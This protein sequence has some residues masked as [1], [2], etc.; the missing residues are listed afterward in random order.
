[1]A[2]VIGMSSSTSGHFPEKVPRDN[3]V[4]IGAADAPRGFFCDPAWTHITYAAAKTGFAEC[5][6][7]ALCIHAGET[8][9]YAFALGLDQG[10]DG[11]LIP[12]AILRFCFF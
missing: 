11:C 1:V 9:L 8:G 5:T 6:G 4:G 7:T 3:R 12:K 10:F 2:A